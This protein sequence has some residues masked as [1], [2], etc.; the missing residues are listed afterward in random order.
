MLPLYQSLLYSKIGTKLAK[1]SL[2]VIAVLKLQDLCLCH[3]QK[4]K[5]NQIQG[6]VILVQ[7]LSY[8]DLNININFEEL[9]LIFFLEYVSVYFHIMRMH[10]L[11]I[12][13]F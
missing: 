4:D 7:G 2:C 12:L 3:R 10:K 1:T 5:L 13:Y 8:L 11:F 6:S 9:L